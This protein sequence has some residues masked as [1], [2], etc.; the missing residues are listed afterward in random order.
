VRGGWGSDSR[1][2]PYLLGQSGDVEW[3]EGFALVVEKNDAGGGLLRSDLLKV[4]EK[5]LTGPFTNGKCSAF[6]GFRL[7]PLNSKTVGGGI[8]VG[9]L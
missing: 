2:L 4:L 9:H 3:G 7:S 1:D 6:S 5:K 8:K